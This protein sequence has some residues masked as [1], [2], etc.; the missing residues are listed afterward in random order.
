MALGTLSQFHSSLDWV[1][2]SLKRDSHGEKKYQIVGRVVSS[3]QGV[4]NIRV[5][6]WDKDLL[7][8]HLVSSAVTGADGRFQMQFDASYF[9]ELFL[10]RQPD[11]F[12]K[13]FYGDQLIKSTED[14]VLWNVAAGKTEIV[15][16]VGLESIL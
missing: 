13:V 5:E 9:S 14:S 11:L 10:D 4:P 3:R 16:E 7:A 8:N 6:A 1:K 15:I 12:F 2:A